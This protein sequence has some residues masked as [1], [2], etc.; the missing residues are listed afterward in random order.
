[1]GIGL[2]PELGP[3]S[4]DQRWQIVALHQLGERCCQLVELLCSPLHAA[5]HLSSQH[6]SPAN[7]EVSLKTDTTRHSETSL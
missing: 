3:G 2:P 1:M 7:R 5:L 6:P 4:Q